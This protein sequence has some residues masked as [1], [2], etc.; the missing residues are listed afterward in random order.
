MRKPKGLEVI[1]LGRKDTDDSDSE[2]DRTWEGFEDA[3]AS[4]SRSGKHSPSV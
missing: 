2:R 4:Y 1:V 3:K